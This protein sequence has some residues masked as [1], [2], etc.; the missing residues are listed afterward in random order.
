[1]RLGFVRLAG[2]RRA[3]GCDVASDGVVIA[4]TPSH[5]LARQFVGGEFY[6]RP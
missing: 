2:N 5:V 4:T 6:Q 1:M 3:P